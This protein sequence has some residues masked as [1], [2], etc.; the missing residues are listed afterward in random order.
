MTIIRYA[1]P[2]FVFPQFGDLAVVGSGQ[3]IGRV[4][5]IAGREWQAGW[6]WA[7]DASMV[8]SQAGPVSTATGKTTLGGWS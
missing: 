4:G 3:K 1:L 5:S 8:S 7:H 6:T 2:A